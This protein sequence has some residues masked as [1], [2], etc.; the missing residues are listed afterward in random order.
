MDIAMTES[1]GLS[2]SKIRDAVRRM[3]FDARNDAARYFWEYVP[4][5]QLHDQDAEL[6]YIISAMPGVGRYPAGTIASLLTAETSLRKKTFRPVP[7]DYK[8]ALPNLARR[9]MDEDPGICL[10]AME[11]VKRHKHVPPEISSDHMWLLQLA[12][13]CSIGVVSGNGMVP[14]ECDRQAEPLLYGHALI[15]R[16]EQLVRYEK[17]MTGGQVS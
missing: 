6:A 14:M 10:R 16:L 9:A 2:M 3:R 11:S 5:D 1:R 7:K 12:I 15:E 17:A 13:A 4:Q 8:F